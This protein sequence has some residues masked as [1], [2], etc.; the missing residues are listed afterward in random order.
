MV[1]RGAMTFQAM[2]RTVTDDDDQPTPVSV[3]P[4]LAA[5]PSP[6]VLPADPRQ[7][8]TRHILG[9][10]TSQLGGVAEAG[11]RTGYRASAVDVGRLQE[12]IERSLTRFDDTRLSAR[13]DE[14]QGWIVTLLRAWVQ[15]AKRLQVE[16]AEKGIRIEIEA[17]DDLGYYTYGFDV[18]P[19]RKPPVSGPD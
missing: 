16:R 8:R 1:G 13:W 2:F 10:L 9:T 14:I 3:F 19:R 17:Q 5:Q 15:R 7:A 18:F 4:P 12:V 11:T 6:A